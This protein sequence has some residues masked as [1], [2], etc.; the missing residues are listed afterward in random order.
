MKNFNIFGFT[1]K[2][3]FKGKEKNNIERGSAKKGG[4]GKKGGDV[5]RGRG[6]DTLL[7]TR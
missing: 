3:D 7:H 5:L 2:S 4:L 6:G 1:E